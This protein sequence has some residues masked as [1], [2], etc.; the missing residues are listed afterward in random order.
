MNIHLIS[1]QQDMEQLSDNM[2][3]LDPA[4]KDFEDLDFE[5]NYISGQETATAHLLSVARDILKE[6]H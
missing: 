3:R 5:Y 6:T 1:L 4:S 2:E